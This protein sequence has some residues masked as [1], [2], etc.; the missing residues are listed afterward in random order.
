[1]LTFYDDVAAM[2]GY[3]G[4]EVIVSDIPLLPSIPGVSPVKLPF[5]QR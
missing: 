3:S 2:P 5:D 1:M 4:G